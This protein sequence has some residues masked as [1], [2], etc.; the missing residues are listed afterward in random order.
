[1]TIN[2][3]DLSEFG[4]ILL[5][6]IISTHDVVQVYDWLDSAASPVYSRTEQRFKDITLT[7]LLES[8]AEAETETQFSNLIL[9]LQSC[10]LVFDEMYKHFTCHFQGKSEPKKITPVV[11]L[12]EVDLKCY[13]TYLPEV[14]VTANGVTHKEITSLGSTPSPCLITITPI[15]AI[16]EF[17]IVGLGATEI[18]LNNLEANKSHVID[19]YLFRYLKDNVNNIANYNAYAWPVLPIGTTDVLFSHTTVD[20]SI[21][22]YPIFN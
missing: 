18:R 21:Q 1:M 7:I 16:T 4:G 3:I 2:E 10:D 13:K 9:A 5:S 20:V 14:L 19:G 6:K 8:E 12:I 17:V 11:W 15:E 22:Y